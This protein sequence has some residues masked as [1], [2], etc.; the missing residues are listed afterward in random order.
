MDGVGTTQGGVLVLGATN[1]PWE[2]DPAMRRR[3]EKRVYIALPDAKSRAKMF[4]LNLGDTPHSITDEEFSLL[5]GCSDG[6][7]GSD[8]AIVVREALMEPLRKCQNA[9]QFIIDNDDNYFPC[10]DYPNCPF[11]PIILSTM[12]DDEI[13]I[14]KTYPCQRCRAQRIS[15][16][17]I[18]SDKLL[19]PVVTF[20]D[21]KKAL[22]KAHSSVGINELKKFVTWTEEFGQDG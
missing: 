18:P 6:Y 13:H 12:N 16:Y 17:D 4:K 7:S 8:V 20:L 10:V 22:T 9:K 5:G 14:A 3:F 21:F 11:C 1:V 15:L 2:L 19:V